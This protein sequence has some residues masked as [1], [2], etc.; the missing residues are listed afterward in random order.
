LDEYIITVFKGSI[1][2]V[3]GIPEHACQNPGA[4]VEGRVAGTW[5]DA[6]ILSFGGSKLLSAGRGGAIVTH[7]PELAQR[8]Q[9]Y[10][11]RGNDAYPLSEMQAAVL[12]PQLKRLSHRNQVRAA[13][14]Q[15]LTREFS[16]AD[17]LFPAVMEAVLDGSG[18]HQ[19][20]AYYKVPF[21]LRSSVSTEHKQAF[22]D[23][24]HAESILLSPG[25]AALHRIHAR[26]R[27]RVA[28]DLSRAEEFADRVLTLH[29]PVLLQSETTLLE[30]TSRVKAMAKVRL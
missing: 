1:K 3:I 9:L 19:G 18:I 20:P 10:T 27:Y 24:C 16:A 12:L 11:Q 23:A 8:L 17:E 7:R 2:P 29:H 25:F 14:V 21:L 22:V 15:K 6:G 4:I 28:G 30:L 5:G 13:S 26:S